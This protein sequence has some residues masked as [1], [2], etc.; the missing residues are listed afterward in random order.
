MQMQLPA[1]IV[2]ALAL[3]P[4][5]CADLRL[6]KPVHPPTPSNDFTREQLE[7]TPAPANERYYVIVFSSQSTPKVPRFTH[8][9]AT[10]IKAT[11]VEG[12][13]EPTLETHTISWMPAT[14]RIHT[15]S[16]RT[17]PGVNL[18]MQETIAA[19]KDT[20]QRV[21]MWGPFALR[22]SGYRR[23]LIQQQFMESH[24][25]GYQCID[26]RGEAGRTGNGCDCIHAITDMDPQF[27][28]SRYPLRWYGEAGGRH[29][30]EEV[31][32]RNAVLDARQ[33][34]DWLIPRLGLDCHD[35]I[36]RCYDG[37]VGD[38]DQP[39]AAPACK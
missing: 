12:Q 23:F 33:T 34:H 27:D 25:I 18:G 20:S 4:A 16:R 24:T 36:R 30:V 3:V 26:S 6:R 13:A 37:P 2:I 22:T 28:R 1:A 11:W 32:R 19:M 15:L 10:A 5:A 38:L 17:E 29:I 31:A 21:S 8:T 7:A 39:A 14:L 35:I 9:W